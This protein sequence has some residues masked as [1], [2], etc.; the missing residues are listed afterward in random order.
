[1]GTIEEMK[2]TIQKKNIKI[3][4]LKYHKVEDSSDDSG[5]QQVKKMGKGSKI[6]FM[7]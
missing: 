3:E 2:N 5:Q 6:E 7:N 4:N 1:M